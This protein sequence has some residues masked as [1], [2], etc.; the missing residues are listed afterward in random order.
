MISSRFFKRAPLVVTSGKTFD[1]II[2]A[3]SE[4]IEL[5][6]KQ[7]PNDVFTLI[8]AGSGIGTLLIPLA[9]KYPKHKFIGLEINYSPYIFSKFRTRNMKNVEVNHGDLFNYNFKDA[10]FVVCFLLDKTMQRF[11]SKCKAELTKPGYIFS[12][13]F[14]LHEMEPI[15]TMDIGD[16]FSYI[17]IYKYTP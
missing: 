3:V 4:K 17:H 8:E 11:T 10:N 12:N 9:K 5:S 13:R 7:N 2:K 6:E 14:K 15:Q 16:N 1:A